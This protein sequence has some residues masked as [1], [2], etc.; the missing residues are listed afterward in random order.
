MV[1][2]RG[3][4]APVQ[5]GPGLSIPDKLGSPGAEEVLGGALGCTS[6]P[7]L[8]EQQPPGRCRK[9]GSRR[10]CHGRGGGS[11]EGALGGSARPTLT[12]SSFSRMSFSVSTSATGGITGMGKSVPLSR[13]SLLWAER[14]GEG[15]R[16]LPQPPGTS[17]HGCP[18]PRRCPAAPPAQ[19]PGPVATTRVAFSRQ[20]GCE[21]LQAPP[22]PQHP[23]PRED[24]GTS[25][26]PPR[27]GVGSPLGLGSPG[28]VFSL[29]L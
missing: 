27:S 7:C 10:L 28:P 18:N 13:V 29:L 16:V 1:P 26:T 9:S 3:H 22:K 19:P 4:A 11:G 14:G 25:S 21:G 15:V 5:V 8:V 23:Q 20:E 2:S 12:S 24:P 6:S 17:P